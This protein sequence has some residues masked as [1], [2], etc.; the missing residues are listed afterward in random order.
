MNDN[1][2]EIFEQVS[3]LFGEYFTPPKL[4]AL[5][6]YKYGNQHI[7][8]LCL[9]KEFTDEMCDE[10]KEIITLLYKEKEFK[11]ERLLRSETLSYNPINNYSIEEDTREVTLP[12]LKDETTFGKTE[13]RTPNLTK[14]T[15]TEFKPVVKNEVKTDGTVTNGVSAFDG[16]DFADNTNSVDD[17]TVT[18]T[19]ILAVDGQGNEIG[20]KTNE[21]ETQTGTDTRA[22]S[23]KDTT[24]KTGTNTVTNHIERKGIT[25]TTSP[26]S[27][28]LQER[29]LANF[30]TISIFMEDIAKAIN[31]YY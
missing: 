6:K 25:G 3:P 2:E 27:M 1:I 22:N 12:N 16:V 10:V 30:S 5:Y 8:Y 9:T 15:N 11:Y 21:S 31:L 23:G 4:F 24:T 28:L 20:D 14:N 29:K 18:N 7:N 13:T 17:T 26:Q 19:P